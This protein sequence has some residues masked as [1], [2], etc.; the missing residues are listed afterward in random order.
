MNNFKTFSDLDFQPHGIP[1]GYQARQHFPNGYSVSVIKGTMFYSN[2]TSTF[3]LAVTD[4]DGSLIYG[5][6]TGG[7]VL[8]YVNKETI[9][10][11][12]QRVQELEAG[13]YPMD[14]DDLEQDMHDA[15]EA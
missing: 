5:H 9:T 12:M 7:D 6:I 2:G 13:S 8:G 11:A 10:I 3:E 1:G 14:S 15:L 4:P